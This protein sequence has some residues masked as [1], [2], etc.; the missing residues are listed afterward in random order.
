[1]KKVLSVL[2]VVAILFSF[3]ACGKDKASSDSNSQ[4][5]TIITIDKY[6]P[7]DLNSMLE[8]VRV[9][10]ENA[11]AQTDADTEAL[12]EHLGK[13][14]D[15]YKT[16]KTEITEF[17]KKTQERS[18]DLY[19]AY[20]ACS[21]DYFKCVA[22][23]GLD[24]YN[25]WDDALGE[26]YDA[27]DDAMGDYYDT[28]DDHY[29]DIYDLC[30]EIIGDASGAMDYEEYSDAWSG[31][32]KEYSE[33]WSAMYEA[34]SNAWSKTYQDYSACW[35]GFYRG[36]SNVDALIAAAGD[37]DNSGNEEKPDTT[38]EAA[39]V[40]T[41]N[42]PYAELEAKIES[43]VQA[44]LA[45]LTAEW[46]NL[47]DGITSYEDYLAK[48]SEIEAF[49][50]KVNGVSEKLCNLMYLYGLD[51]AKAVMTSGKSSYKMYS[52]MGG[53][54]DVIY[55]GM[56]GKIYDEI[57]SGILSDMYDTF[58]SGVLGNRPDGVS[59]SEWADVRSKEYDMWSDARSD[60]YDH[61]SDA[62]SDVYDFWSDVRSD[63]FDEDI[64]A[65]Q[66]EID[67]FQKDVDKMLN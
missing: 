52:E 45:A 26:F 55:S 4:G 43:E 47:R 39:N 36:D 42:D 46:E 66:K 35:S 22:A 32:Y 15:S 29:S 3:G 23:Q 59:Y 33:S 65:A 12:L 57:Y 51:Y 20:Q 1:M 44:E 37:K 40:T 64:G 67:D 13:D 63:L 27:W 14:Y 56:G 19:A 38:T 53:L 58:Y 54:Y 10:S 25:K 6:N 48:A 18:K 49:Y 34:Y 24:D 61:W 9:E 16:H 62:R 5:N 31:M 17:Y 11:C 2:L 60:T 7:N 30:D 50:A 8:Y 28:W 21:V 41:P